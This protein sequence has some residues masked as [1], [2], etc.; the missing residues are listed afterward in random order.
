M[1]YYYFWAFDPKIMVLLYQSTFQVH[2][3]M[4]APPY[5]AS[6]FMDQIKLINLNS[7]DHYF[8]IDTFWTEQCLHLT[9]GYCKVVLPTLTTPS[10]ALPYYTT[11]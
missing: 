3:T 5:I 9:I 7:H 2:F 4:L 10:L 11:L 6:N 8:I 1:V